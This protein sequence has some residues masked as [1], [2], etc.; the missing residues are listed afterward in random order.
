[1]KLKPEIKQFIKD[2]INLIDADDWNAFWDLL[3]KK[4]RYLKI[5]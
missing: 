2:N 3:R 1:M 5:C 4:V